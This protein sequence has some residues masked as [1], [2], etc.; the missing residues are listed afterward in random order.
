M[1][2]LEV[3]ETWMRRVWNEQETSVIHEMFKVDGTA[4]GLGQ[5]LVGPKD[6]EVFHAQMLTLIDN[7]DVQVIKHFQDGSWSSAYC[8]LECTDRNDSSRKV[9]ITGN[10]LLRIED[11]TI[12]EAYNHF[13]FMGM[14]EQ[15]GY[16][17]EG[18]FGQCLSGHTVSAKALMG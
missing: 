4:D 3:I 9:R 17:P 18:T 12:I 15:L 10:V 13:D 6:F 8:S 14:F 5:Q 16:L 2:N 11:D 7:V 1:T